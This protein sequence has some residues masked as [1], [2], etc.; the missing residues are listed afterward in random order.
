MAAIF[1]NRSNIYLSFR[2]AGVAREPGI[3]GWLGV[4]FWIPGPALRAVAE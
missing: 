3:Q 2:A 4:R 1:G